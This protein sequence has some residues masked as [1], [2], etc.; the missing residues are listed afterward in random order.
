L[1]LNKINNL[2]RYSKYRRTDTQYFILQELLK[3]LKRYQYIDQTT[4][5]Q[6]NI[7]RTLFT[8]E[9][10]KLYLDKRNT[11]SKEISIIQDIYPNICSDIQDIIADYGL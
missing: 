4:Y 8:P 5:N 1:N 6:T 3:E 11:L 9:I 7:I 10:K 2:Y